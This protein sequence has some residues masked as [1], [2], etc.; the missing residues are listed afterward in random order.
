MCNSTAVCSTGQSCFVQTTQTSP[1]IRYEMG[2]QNNQL[3]TSS[4]LHGGAG[5]IGRAL[6]TRQVTACH[7]CCLSD[8][9]NERLCAHRKPTACIDS[10]SVD[11][12]LLNSLLNVC[13]DVDHAKTICPKY[14]GLCSLVDGNWADWSTWSQCDVTCESGTQLRTR[15]CTNPA[16][17]NGGLD[18]VGSANQ[19]KVCVKELCPVHGGW[20]TWTSWGSCSVSC[21]AGLATRRRNCNNPKPDRFGDHCFGDSFEARICMQRPCAGKDGGWS[22]WSSWGVCEEGQLGRNRS[23]NNPEPS[24]S[25]KQCAGTDM[26]TKPCSLQKCYSRGDMVYFIAHSY[27]MSQAHY[28]IC[29]TVV[30]NVGNGYHSNNGSFVAPVSG[31]YSFS[32]QICTS[33][34]KTLDVQIRDGIGHAKGFKTPLT[35]KDDVTPKFMKARSV[36]FSMKSKIEKELNNLEREGKFTKVNTSEWATPI[37]SVFKS[38]GDVMIKGYFKVTVNQALKVDKYPLPRVDDIFANLSQGQKFTKLDSRQAYLHFEVD[39]SKEVLTINTLYRYNRS[40]YGI[41][42]F[43]AIWQRTMDTIF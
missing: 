20:S 37:V 38:T 29:P 1:A 27:E 17:N 9:C 23:C 26:Q 41:A 5:I 36:P 25:G 40:L 6:N 14:C 15:T 43:P 18:C 34:T 31:Q 10:A 3:C 8:N 11:C 42:S 33:D 30:D 19:T 35:L 32:A 12:A 4:N 24:V 22:E 7:E 13:T 28:L 21:D 39:D 2:C 16:P